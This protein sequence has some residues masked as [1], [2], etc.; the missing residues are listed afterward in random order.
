MQKVQFLETLEGACADL[1][2]VC[3]PVL[4]KQIDLQLKGAISLI[5]QDHLFRFG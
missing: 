3:D 5:W 2:I 1:L 4:Q